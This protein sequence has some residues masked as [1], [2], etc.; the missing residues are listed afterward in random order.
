MN[1]RA[2]G[3]GLSVCV[4]PLSA[5]QKN[6]APVRLEAGD[7]PR[8]VNGTLNQRA[9]TGSVASTMAETAAIDSSM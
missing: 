5:M 7:V 9:V 3:I 6:D 8:I 1:W 4:A 2:V